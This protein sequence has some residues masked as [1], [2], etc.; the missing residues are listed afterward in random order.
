MSLRV[1]LGVYEKNNKIIGFNTKYT[2][3]I[4]GNF[5]KYI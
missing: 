1:L 2:K 5:R 3:T 4:R